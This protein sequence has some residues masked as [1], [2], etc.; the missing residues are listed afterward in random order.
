[1]NMRSASRPLNC[2]MCDEEITDVGYVPAKVIEDE[3]KPHTQDAVCGT[4]GFNQI[5]MMGCAPGLSDI[6]DVDPDD[7]PEQTLLHIRMKDDNIIVTNHK[8]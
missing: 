6:T 7:E 2:S 5:G 3:Y 4:C 8:G 1:M